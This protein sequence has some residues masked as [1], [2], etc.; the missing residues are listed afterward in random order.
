MVET[1]GPEVRVMPVP[2]PPGTPQAQQQVVP[3]EKILAQ[4][5][6][7]HL[8]L[9][10]AEEAVQN[11]N[12][13]VQALVNGIEQLNATI[14]EIRKEL[15]DVKQEN[16]RLKAGTYYGPLDGKDEPHSPEEP[17]QEITAPASN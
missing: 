5:G 9:V 14:R 7:E 6:K 13:R 1:K 10:M 11:L 12:G 8:Q 3:M 4:L 15:E 2:L 17:K 16:E